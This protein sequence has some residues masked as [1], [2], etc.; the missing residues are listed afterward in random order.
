MSRNKHRAKELRSFSK[1]AMRRQRDRLLREKRKKMDD[2][3]KES[4]GKHW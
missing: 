3:W 1:I 2:K 4:D